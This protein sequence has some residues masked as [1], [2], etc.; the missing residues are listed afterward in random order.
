MKSII[1]CIQLDIK[2]GDPDFNYQ[3]VEEKVA[4]AVQQEHS[5]TVVL[6]E[7]WTTGY[8][9]TRLDEISDEN[10]E[11]TTSFLQKLA[12]KYNILNILPILIIEKMGPHFAIGD[13]CFMWQ[14]DHKIY[15]VIDHKEMIAKDNEKSILRRDDIM[16]A[17]TNVHTDMTL[18]YESIEYIASVKKDGTRD[19]IIKDGIFVVEGTEELNQALLT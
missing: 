2:F 4:Q 1:T 14:E 16:Q 11:K 7:L 6:P 9:L 5:T 19:Y 8:D 10:G 15:N 17:Y 18:L 13:T 12:K 3:Q